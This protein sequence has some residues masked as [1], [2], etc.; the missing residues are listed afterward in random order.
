[1][2]L[3]PENTVLMEIKTSG[4]VPLWMTKLLTEEHIFKTAFSKYGSAYGHY[5]FPQQEGVKNYVK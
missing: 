2:T 3:L 1:M 4:G 5:I